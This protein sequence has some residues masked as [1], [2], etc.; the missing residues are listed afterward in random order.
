MSFIKK[1]SPQLG[2]AIGFASKLIP[3][4]GA[5]IVGQAVGNAIALN[6]GKEKKASA[7]SFMPISQQPTTTNQ[8]KME[9]KKTLA[10]TFKAWPMWAKI[11][12]P[13]VVV[14]LILILVFKRKK[15]R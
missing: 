4:P 7:A 12:A 10:E 13:A 9:D 8:P 14:V 3:L 2:K 6:K 11:A 5:S 15:R 1:L